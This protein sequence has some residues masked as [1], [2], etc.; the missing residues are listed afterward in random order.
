MTAW[1][2]KIAQYQLCL[3]MDR[4]A[5][6]YRN[7]LK[8]AQKDVPPPAA[9]A[10]CVDPG[11]YVAPP[12]LAASPARGRGRAFASPYGRRTAQ[13]ERNGG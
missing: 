1:T 10:P 13:H 2:D 5:E 12:T 11:P 9:T 3:A 7:S 4:T 6:R 8:A